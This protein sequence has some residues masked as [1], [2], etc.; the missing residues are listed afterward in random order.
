MPKGKTGK[1]RGRPGWVTGTKLVYLEHYFTEWKTVWEA[2]KVGEFYTL[3]MKRLYA[4]F[5]EQAEKGDATDETEDPEDEALD[6]KMDNKTKE[7]LKEKLVT[8]SMHVIVA[9]AREKKNILYSLFECVAEI[10]RLIEEYHAW[11]MKQY[12]FARDH[13]GTKTGSDYYL[14]LVSLS[15]LLQ[16]LV[17]A[18]QDYFGMATTILLCGPIPESGGNV[19]VQSLKV[20]SAQECQNQALSP[21]ELTAA[22][23]A[24]QA[25]GVAG[26]T[27]TN[28][29]F[30]GHPSNSTRV[31][32]NIAHST[33]NSGHSTS[34][35]S[36]TPKKTSSTTL[37]AHSRSPVLGKAFWSPIAPDAHSTPLDNLNPHPLMKLIP[38]PLTKLV[39]QVLHPAMLIPHPQMMLMQQV[40]HPIIL[41]LHS[42]TKLV[43][44]SMSAALDNTPSAPSDK[45]HSPSVVPNNAPSVPHSMGVTPN[46][47]H[48]T[49]SMG[50][51]SDGG[52]STPGGSCAASVAPIGAHSMSVTPDKAHST[53]SNRHSMSTTP[54]DTASLDRE[55]PMAELPEWIHKFYSVF[56][57][58]V[59]WDTQW[60]DCIKLYPKFKHKLGYK[61]SCGKNHRNPQRMMKVWTPEI[62]SRWREEWWT[63][64]HSIQPQGQV[65]K[66]KLVC[67][68]SL[69]W[70]SLQ[71]KGGVDGFLLIMLTLL[72]WGHD[73]HSGNWQD[74]HPANSE[75]WRLAVADVCLDLLEGA[76]NTS[77]S[78]SVIQ[79]Q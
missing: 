16:K 70:S 43:E 79:I 32:P 56:Q 42:Q 64:W 40:L 37:N 51:A 54:E 60:F 21:Q 62:G 25:K 15:A 59:S 65:Q 67:P 38:Y 27:G 75:G 11:N 30:E 7:E 68:E 49:P 36:D 5:G 52:H 23:E 26:S 46:N 39:Q 8:G 3:M 55:W 71:D 9:A 73:T 48:S 4:K 47:T 57:P 35:A 2:G 61:E 28:T 18:C 20:F 17:N 19:E 41:L 77:G 34:V 14:A 78:G 58:T 72:W 33:A 50:V 31:G 53:S 22:Q 63:Y 45:T 13:P 74:E 44:R 66:D 29:N 1:L 10:R 69:D 6:I 12:N 24:L 76:F